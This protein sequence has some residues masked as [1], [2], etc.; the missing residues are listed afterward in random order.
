MRSLLPMIHFDLL[1]P[2][3]AVG[4]VPQ[5]NIFLSDLFSTITHSPEVTFC[6]FIVKTTSFFPPIQHFTNA[7]LFSFQFSKGKMMLL[8]HILSHYAQVKSKREHPSLPPPPPPNR[9][10]HHLSSFAREFGKREKKG[11]ERAGGGGGG[12]G[13]GKWAVKSC[14]TPQEITLY[15]FPVA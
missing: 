7:I 8:V 3:S 5:K 15:V 9:H 12:E 2:V 6:A 1:E 10:H 14:T 11:G 13:E 4:Y